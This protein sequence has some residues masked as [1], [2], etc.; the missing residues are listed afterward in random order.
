MQ[1]SG[2]GDRHNNGARLGE[3]RAPLR[4]NGTAVENVL[5]ELVVV[6]VGGHTT[7]SEVG[8]VVGFRSFRCFCCIDND[9]LC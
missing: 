8:W 4:R 2:V 5:K 9:L 3:G 7:N 1:D 6:E